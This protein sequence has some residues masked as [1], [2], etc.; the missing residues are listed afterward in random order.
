MRALILALWTML[1]IDAPALSQS[2]YQFLRHDIPARTAALGG[3]FL[4]MQDDPNLLFVNPAGL[5]TVSSRQVSIGYLDHLLDI[6]AGSI[7]FATEWDGIGPVAIGAQFYHYGSFDRTDALLNTSG[8]FSAVDLALSAGLAHE[9]APNLSVGGALT[10]IHAS[11][12]DYRSTGVAVDAGVLYRIPEERLAIGASILHAG[13]QL[14]TFNGVR[15]DLP[16]DVRVGVS[17][18]PEHLPVFLN[19]N[20]HRLQEDAESIGERFQRF[21]AGAEFELSPSLRLR[22]GYNN[23]LRKELRLGSSAGLA[24]FSG[25]FGVTV[26]GYLVDYAFN[27]YGS[28]GG[29]HR[30]SVALR[31]P[32]QP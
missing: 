22:L 19:L 29:L 10:F 28:I 20:L 6:S 12:A 17:K 31:L 21:S 32:S 25:G 24:G 1:W 27:S 9:V 7:A 4:A 14:S 8:T 2:T 3:A 5:A 13:A 18:R 26:A 11:I 15:E 30:I 16:L 23:Q